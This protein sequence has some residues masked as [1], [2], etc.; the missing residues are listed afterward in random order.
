[1]LLV[2]RNNLDNALTVTHSN[3]DYSTRSLDSTMSL[4][5]TA[6]TQIPVIP[7][8]QPDLILYRDHVSTD[9]F[10]MDN[11]SSYNSSDLN[12]YNP[13]SLKPSVKYISKTSSSLPSRIVNGLIS[14]PTADTLGYECSLGVMNNIYRPKR[15]HWAVVNPRF[16]SR[17][18]ITKYVDLF[19][20]VPDSLLLDFRLYMPNTLKFL[21]S[22]LDY[23]DLESAFDSGGVSLLE[24]FPVLSSYPDLIDHCYITL[25]SQYGGFVLFTSFE[26]ENTFSLEHSF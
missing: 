19:G 18:Y 8:K 12:F 10:Y 20:S 21:Q 22:E 5:Q 13:N 4:Q 9:F 1:M 16:N 11:I 24:I 17:I 2:W 23:G 15:F 6:Y 7:N 14:P 25:F 3:F 26:K